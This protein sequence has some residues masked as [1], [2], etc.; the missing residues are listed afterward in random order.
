[1]QYLAVKTTDTAE[2]KNICF[3]DAPAPANI[4][5]QHNKN[6][7]IPS[8]SRAHRRHFSY[9][10]VLFSQH[11]AWRVGVRASETLFE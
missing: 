9:W 10:A 3:A 1:M 6:T 8:F 7:L 4:L 11:R 2:Q 5:L